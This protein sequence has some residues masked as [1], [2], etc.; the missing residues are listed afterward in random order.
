MI[1]LRRMPQALTALGRRF[2]IALAVGASIS[3]GV[4]SWF[5]YRAIVEWRNSSLL[6]AERRT[7]EAAD[8][9]LQALIRDMRGVQQS[10]LTSTQWIEFAPDRPS[11][12]SS[13]VA[14]AFALYPY[15]ES[16]FIWHGEADPSRLVFFNRSNRR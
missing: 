12:A 1:G 3:L 14:A 5:G 10:I 2:T 15:P 16:F 11:E 6:V 9:V 13:V 4:L 8:L 7:T